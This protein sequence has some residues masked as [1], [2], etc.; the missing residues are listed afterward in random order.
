[1]G[2]IDSAIEANER[3][4]R[5]YDP[6]SELSAIGSLTSFSSS[7]FA[8]LEEQRKTASDQSEYTTTLLERSSESLSK[9][10]GVNLDEELVNLTT[11][12]QAY[13]ASGRLIQNAF[14][15]SSNIRNFGE[16]RGGIQIPLDGHFRSDA[17]PGFVQV[18]APVDSQDVAAGFSHGF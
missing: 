6:S 1:M 9:S 15:V 12:Q 13:S 4:A 5:S 11:Y 10:T 16:E 3:Y 18:D 14:Y 2:L 8:W 7:S 17:C